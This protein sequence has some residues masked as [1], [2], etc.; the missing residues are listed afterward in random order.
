MD[1]LNPQGYSEQQLNHHNIQLTKIT[2]KQLVLQTC[3]A[4]FAYFLYNQ[5]SFYVLTNVEMVTHAVGNSFRRVVTICFSVFYFGNE[6]K[7][8][9]ALGI[10]LAISGVAFYS[11]AKT[12]QKTK[13]FTPANA[14]S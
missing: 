10:F 2:Q 8:M 5:M 11:Y 3:A 7:P 12:K 9:N 1:K 14:G 6:I 13:L 4:C